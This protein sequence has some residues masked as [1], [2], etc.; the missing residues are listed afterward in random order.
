MAH[1]SVPASEFPVFVKDATDAWIAIEG[2]N[3]FTLTPS[4]KEGDNS[5]FDNP[6]VERVLITSRGTMMKID[7]NAHWDVDSGARSAGQARVL[8]FA[9]E[10]GHLAVASFRVLLPGDQEYLL[11]GSVTATAFGGGV[12]DLAKFEVEV[13]AS[14]DPIIQAIA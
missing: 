7:G 10:R 4:S 14:E 3:T 12:N 1:D 13:K 2:V 5:D 8:S 11:T 9:G 6:G